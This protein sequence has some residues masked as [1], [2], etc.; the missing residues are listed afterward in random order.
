[1]SI[2]TRKTIVR[3]SHPLFNDP[4]A[5]N[6][7][8]LPNVTKES[9]QSGLGSGVIVN[10]E[11]YILTNNHVIQGAD[12]I[13][14]ELKDKRQSRAQLSGSDQDTDL[15]VLKISLEKTPFMKNIFSDITVG[16][17]ELTI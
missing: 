15:S 14:V 16:D 2:Y 17:I 5:R 10:A 4:I 3:L 6:F 1:V 7:F 9:I 12:E 13:L 8:G 11:G